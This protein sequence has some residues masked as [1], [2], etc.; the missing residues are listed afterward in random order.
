MESCNRAE[1]AKFSPYPTMPVVFSLARWTQAKNH[2]RIWSSRWEI[3]NG[4]YWNVMTTR[5][6]ASIIAG[7]ANIP[8]SVTH[9]LADHNVSA[10][11]QDD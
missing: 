8:Y 5:K 3:H 9:E 2:Q 6:H 1:N 10:A 4:S 11:D 7:T